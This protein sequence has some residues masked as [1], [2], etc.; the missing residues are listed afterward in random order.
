MKPALTLISGFLALLFFEGFARLII[1]F[2]HRIAFSFYGVSGLPSLTWGIAILVSVLIST[3][4]TTMLIL[5]ILDERIR[6][7]AFFFLG[8]IL[9]W[10]SIEIANSY[11]SEPLWYFGVLIALHILGVVLAILLYERQH[12]KLH[13]A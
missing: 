1:S 10:R 4:L 8:I 6:F 13:S 2:Y 5:T 12:E 7:Y 9:C 3:W 11:Q